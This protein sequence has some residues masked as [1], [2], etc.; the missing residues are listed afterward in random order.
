MQDRLYTHDNKHDTHVLKLAGLRSETEFRTNGIEFLSSSNQNSMSFSMR[1]EIDMYLPA[2]NNKHWLSN[3][4]D[5]HHSSTTVGSNVQGI[6]H[7]LQNLH[8][9]CSPVLG[10]DQN[11]IVKSQSGLIPLLSHGNCVT[12][13]SLCNLDS[14]VL[15]NR[16][17]RSTIIP[18]F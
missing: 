16:N 13:M 10:N 1:F 7:G 14:L 8:L 9:T 12:I 6:C 4:E 18:Y 15:L 5:H 3:D 11:L 17:F 2:R